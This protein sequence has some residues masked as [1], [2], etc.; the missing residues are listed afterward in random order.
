MTR[1]LFAG[2]THNFTSM[3]T[4]PQRPIYLEIRGRRNFVDELGTTTTPSTPRKK[5]KERLNHQQRPLRQ[6]EYQSQATS[7]HRC[8]YHGAPCCCAWCERTRLTNHLGGRLCPAKAASAIQDKVEWD[9]VLPGSDGLTTIT[10]PP[11]DQ[12]GPEQLSRPSCQSLKAGPTVLSDPWIRRP[13]ICIQ[14]L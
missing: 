11:V 8:R 3:R 10:S 14:T 7:S 2:T 1:K 13:R 12:P 5:R 9:F 6:Q 4:E